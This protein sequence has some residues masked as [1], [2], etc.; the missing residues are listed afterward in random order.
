M[1]HLP[2]FAICGWLAIS[3]GLAPV[4]IQAGEHVHVLQRVTSLQADAA[5]SAKT[6]RPIIVLLSLPGCH[7]CDEV[8][9]SYLLPLMNDADP[10]DRPILREIVLTGSQQIVGFAGE[11]TS[12]Q[13]V[14]K[15]YGVRVAPTVLMINAAGVLLVPPVVG[16]DTSGLYGGYLSNAL[17]QATRMVQKK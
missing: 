11:Q 5:L 15:H 10:A 2:N 1:R 12:E 9:Q 3:V 7:F 14:A 13:L 4:P 6:H 17:D 8:R 16:G